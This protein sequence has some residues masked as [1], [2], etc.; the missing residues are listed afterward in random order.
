[1]PVI[2]VFKTNVA[3]KRKSAGLQQLLLKV[4]DVERCNFDLEDRDR[5]LRVL[6]R[7]KL[8]PRKIEE[9]LGGSGFLCE[10]LPD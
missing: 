3:S 2:L 8:C 9:I 4:E 10:E 6:G 1:M 7:E 5:I